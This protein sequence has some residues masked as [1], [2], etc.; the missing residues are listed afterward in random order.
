MALNRIGTGNRK[1]RSE[2]NRRTGE[3]VRTGEPAEQRTGRTANRDAR[4]PGCHFFENH[5]FLTNKLLVKAFDAMTGAFC[6][7]SRRASFSENHVFLLFGPKRLENYPFELPFSEPEIE[8]HEQS[9]KHGPG[10]Q[11]TAR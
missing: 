9:E 3:G 6:M 7:K 5:V 2:P 8:F 1:D 10:D 4:I 11:K